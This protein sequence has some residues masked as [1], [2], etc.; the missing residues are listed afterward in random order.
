MK[1][2][3]KLF[4]CSTISLYNTCILNVNCRWQGHGIVSRSDTMSV[5]MM[6][7]INHQIW[8]LL[9]HLGSCLAEYD[10]IQAVP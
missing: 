3:V 9:K 10:K 6:S 7:C 1:K 8:K 2:N 4:C 5:P